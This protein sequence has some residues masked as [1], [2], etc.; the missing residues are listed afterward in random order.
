MEKIKLLFVCMGNL[1]RSPTAQHLFKDSKKYKAKSC[2]VDSLSPTM[3]SKELVKW[4]NMIF[5]M[6]DW[7]K[8]KVLEFDPDTAVVVL[9]IPDIYNTN[10][11]EL[12]KILKE[13]LSHHINL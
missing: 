2:G 9:N 10:D 4:A 11:P 13:K 5:V 3:I 6:E 8:E 1:N 12:I 7:H